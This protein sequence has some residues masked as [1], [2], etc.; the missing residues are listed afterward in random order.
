MKDELLPYK[1]M[2]DAAYPMR[3]WIYSPFKGE[4]DELPRI[5][6]HWNF[7]QS[8]TKMAVERAFDILKGRWRIILKRFDMP[9]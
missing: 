2:G 8:L 9:L 5:K 3:P 7:I 4:K 1:L 6:T